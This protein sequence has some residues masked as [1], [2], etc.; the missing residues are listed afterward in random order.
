MDLVQHEIPQHVAD[1]NRVAGDERDRAIEIA[2]LQLGDARGGIAMDALKGRRQ[3]LDFARSLDSGRPCVARESSTL[4]RE[5]SVTFRLGE[6]PGQLAERASFR[7]GAEV[8]AAARPRLE[9]KSVV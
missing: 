1:R 5:A 4:D 2:R 8:I 9:Q 7:I 3:L 6:M